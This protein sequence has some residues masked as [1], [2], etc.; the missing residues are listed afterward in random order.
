[1]PFPTFS[2]GNVLAASD[3]N[4]VGLWLVKTQTI[5]SAVT[6]VTIS[7]C[8][9]TDYDDY[10]VTI[11]D[12]S[13]TNDNADLSMQL[14]TGS[15]TAATNYYYVYQYVTYSSTLSTFAAGNNT[16]TWAFVGRSTNNT[17]TARF[18]ISQPRLARR[19]NIRC[20]TPGGNIAGPMNGFHDVA[21]A[22][23]SMIFTLGAGTMSGGTVRV[24][25]YRK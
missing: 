9:T 2:A 11:S 1:M 24:Y 10:V 13:T 25:G 15:T 19:T 8:F 16:T 18:D 20:Q 3:M 7:N 12:T 23:E 17:I 4:A 5:G 21:T 14:R 6:T 22:Y